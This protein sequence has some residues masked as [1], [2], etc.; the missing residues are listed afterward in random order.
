MMEPSGSEKQV[1]VIGAGLAG[2]CALRRLSENK[3]FKLTCFER[4]YDIGGQWLYTDQ[5]VED[6]FG[7]P[8]QTAM[9][10]NVR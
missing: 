2:I 1:L 6:D 10:K 8:I 4:N 5:T 9:Y 7:R 3:D